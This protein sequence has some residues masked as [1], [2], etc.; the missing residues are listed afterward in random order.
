MSAIIKEDGIIHYEV[1]GHGKPVIF[2]HSWI[3][4]WRY[5]IPSMQFVSSRYR[6]Y[7]FDFW[8]F[9]S[10]KKVVSRYAIEKQVD[11]LAGFIRQMGI[12]RAT[13]V[14]HGLGSI[15]GTYF[16][17]DFSHIVEKLMLVSFPMGLQTAHSRLQSQSPIDSAAWLFGNNSANAESREDARKADLKAIKISFD[18]FNGVNW[19]QLINRLPVSSL[20]IYGKNDQAV[21]SPSLDQVDLLP[22]SSQMHLFEQSGHFPMLDEPSKFNRLLI[23]FVNLPPGEDP[24]SLELKSL[25]KRRVR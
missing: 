23:D 22:S 21:S 2:L 14:G 19:R 11:L 18:Q 17:A 4:S 1:L 8:G 9:G 7:A 10:S 5:W 24:S 25:W 20:W 16:A 3:G 12:G 15:I 13:L 6:A